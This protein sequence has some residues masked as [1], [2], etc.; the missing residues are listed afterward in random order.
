MNILLIEDDKKLVKNLRKALEIEG[1]NVVVAYDGIAGFRKGLN[2]K[3]DLII[4][5]LM[6]PKKDGVEICKE[7]RKHNVQIP[8]IMLTAKDSPH[9]RVL[10]LDS[11]ADDYLVKPFG[12]PELFARLRSL[13]RRRK[14]T[15]RP[16][17]R[18]SNLVLNPSTREVKR[19]RKSIHLTPKEYKLLE[20]LLRNANKALTRMELIARLWK[21]KPKGNELDV[22]IRYL[23]KKVDDGYSKKLIHTVKSVGYKIKN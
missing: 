7:L 5:D 20:Y 9:D 3:H 18:I 17:L 8:I 11:G 10:G 2:T 15:D 14:T 4:L 16:I 19:G 22:H 1:Y 13:A 6:L 23:R 12:L 21:L